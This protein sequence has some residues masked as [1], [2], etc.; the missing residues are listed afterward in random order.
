MKQAMDLAGRAHFIAAWFRNPRQTGALWPSGQ[1]LARAMA[2]CVDPGQQGPVVELGAG[3]GAITRE[4]LA[5]GLS[6]QR[7]IAIEKDPALCRVLRLRFPE[8]IVLRGDVA[9]LAALLVA[10]G[11]GRAGT[12]VSGL[13]LLGMPR[14]GRRRVL[15]QIAACLGPGG[16]F[17][18]FTY[19]PFQPVARAA[20]AALGWSGRRVAWVPWNLPPAAVWVYTRRTEA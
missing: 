10:A 4:L 8:A 14:Q 20:C 3:T 15:E 19:S 5:H 18:Q 12:L 17:V 9:E 2:R 6:P 11:A 13:P 16:A 1:S 7:L